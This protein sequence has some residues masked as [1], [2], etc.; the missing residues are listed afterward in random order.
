MTMRKGFLGFGIAVALALVAMTVFMADHL[1]TTSASGGGPEMTL[2]VGDCTD[3][4]DVAL[5]GA[6]T[7]SVVVAT[8]PDGGYTGAQ[9]F[10][11]FGDDLIY[12]PT[13]AA[14]DEVVWPDCESATV[15]RSQLFGEDTVNHGCLTGLLPPQP[16]STATGAWATLA[17]N[18]SSAVST[19]V[20]QILPLGD[21]LASTSGAGFV[22]ADGTTQV[23]AKGGSLTISCGGGGGDPTDTPGTPAEATDTPV[24]PTNTPVPPT[25]TPSDQLCGDINDDGSVDSRDALWVLWFTAGLVSELDK[26]GDMNGDGEVDSRDAALILQIDAGLYS[27]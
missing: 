7:L 25:A 8:A 19:T 15:V 11:Q 13:D 24:P 4:C 23:A 27:C 3:S 10:V 17:F 20:V 2:A 14:R 16:V 26:D 12:K 21:D 18:C 22:Q 5:D 1:T 6:F 9:A